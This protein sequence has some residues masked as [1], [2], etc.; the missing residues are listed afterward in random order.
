MKIISSYSIKGGVGKT[1][2]SVNLAY[3][4]LQ[5]GFRTLLVDLDPQ[6][7]A[8]FY[9]R[10]D[11]AEKLPVHKNEMSIKGL[12]DNIRESDFPNLDI[13]PSNFSY[14]KLDI[15][16]N[17]M[18]KSRNQLRRVL[19][20][21]GANYEAIILDCPPNI[22]LLSENVFRAADMVLVPVI[23]TTLSQRTLEQLIEF[24]EKKE[25]PVERIIPFFSM[26][27]KSRKLHLEMMKELPETFPQFL[28]TTIPLAAS[29]EKMGLHRA[30]IMEFDAK[31][32]A[33][34]AY[35]ALSKE[36]LAKHRNSCAQ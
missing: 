17:D 36:I 12:R 10:V 9:F 19:E 6:G 35:R 33:G 30:P 13:L 28:K 23:P 15:L 26:V 21:I 11:P 3:E 14:R 20:E 1:S 27:Q 18:K 7:A 32:P 22:T 31:C 29:V 2:L 4:F 8:A 16:L 34:Q 24:F 25:L 5:A